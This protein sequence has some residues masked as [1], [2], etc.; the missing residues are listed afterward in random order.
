[1]FFTNFL[2]EF[3]LNNIDIKSK[4]NLKFNNFAYQS[5]NYNFL[6][7]KFFF[8]VLSQFS[9]ISMILS[10]N[11]NTYPLYNGKDLGVTFTKTKTTIK[12]WSP[13]A[14]AMTLRVYKFGNSIENTKDIPEEKQ[15]KKNNQGVW[16]TDLM[17]NYEGKFYTLQATIGG[18]LMNEVTDPYTKAV[19]V[20]GLRGQIIDL[21]KTNPKNWET[22][23]SPLFLQKTDAI[24]YELHVRDAS[25]AANSGIK[26]KG[27]FLGLTEKGTKNHFKQ[28]TGLD[29]LKEFGITH[30]H[31]LPLYDYFTTDE[32]I[33]DNTQ[34]NWGYDPLNYNCPEGSYSTNPYDG[35]VRIQEFK[36]LVQTFHQNGLRVVMD[37]VYNHTM[38][39]ETSNFN[40]LVPNYY[41]RQTADG[42][43]SNASGCGNETASDRA[44]FQKFMLESLEYWVKEYHVDGF[45]FD[46]MGVHDIETMNL[47]SKRL[48]QLRPDILL[49]GEG[50]T[51]GDSPLPEERRS[52][53]KYISKI[54]KIAAFSDDMR[55]GLKGSVFEKEDKGFVSGKPG[56][57]ESIKFG[58]VAS[59]KHPQVNYEK[60]I[61][62][63]APWAAEPFQCINY[64]ECHDNHT[65]FDRLENSNKTNTA[66]EK[67]KMH[68]LAQTIFLTSQGIP[69]I[70]AGME[71]SRTKKGE[72]NSFKS[73]DDINEIDWDRKKQYEAEYNFLKSLVQLR[74]AHPAFRIPTTK[75]IQKHLQFLDCPEKNMVAFRINGNAN[76]DKWKNILVVYN[77]NPTSVNFDIPTGNWKLVLDGLKIDHDAKTLVTT[78][79]L[80]VQPY[81]ALIIVE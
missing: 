19:G 20:N 81:S 7:M 37:V 5:E 1:M 16:S 69:F 71:F 28:S 62:A 49:Y 31:L 61:Y 29:H 55:D 32:T 76:K 57:E 24:L 66:Q 74:K 46:L 75:L 60:V 14:E 8:S 35:N 65:L 70:H 52:L 50:W 17:G 59:T 42:K 4:S 47:I 43:F 45:R 27:K 3:I 22:D 51:S 23:K 40:Q 11:F 13:I 80:E 68:I 6:K 79:R 36:K 10:Q 54:D 9:F 56:M 38:F 34:Y 72:E 77:A 41:Y 63:K 44:M 48:H 67:T 21:A 15:M 2:L 30:V 12:V 39:G 73:P 58:A 33:K 26:N 53:K 78:K 64:A 18:K 25:I